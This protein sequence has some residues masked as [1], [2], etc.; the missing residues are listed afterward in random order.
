M[1][2]PYVYNQT[3]CSRAES[4]LD[5]SFFETSLLSAVVA[6]AINDPNS[7]E[8]R[9]FYSHIAVALEGQVESFAKLSR[10]LEQPNFIFVAVTEEG[11]SNQ[12]ARKLI[13]G[14]FASLVP[15]YDGKA[16]LAV[17]FIHT[18]PDARGS[19]VS[20][21]A[22]DRLFLEA[23]NLAAAQ[24]LEI[25]SIVGETAARVER[26]INKIEFPAERVRKRTYIE[27]PGGDLREFKYNTAPLI[28]DCN[29]EIICDA[30]AA[31]LMFAHSESN[32]VV[33]SAKLV[34]NSRTWWQQWYHSHQE[35]FNSASAWRRHVAQLDQSFCQTF[36]QQLERVDVLHLLS[37][38]ERETMKLDGLRVLDFEY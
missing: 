16:M 23:K 2:I 28:F 17:R 32:N 35:E 24:N 37:W 3:G 5:T 1:S 27:M 26:F 33:S 36:E 31:H 25:D 6:T 30:T 21:V 13:S 19:G 18:S 38:R 10:E 11:N 29:G 15:L 8:F 34:D 20:L 14:I 4:E 12:H 9:Q 22:Y 7:I